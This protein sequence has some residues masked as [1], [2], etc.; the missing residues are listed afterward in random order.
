[1]EHVPNK[2]AFSKV[3]EQVMH[4][5][6]KLDA[7]QTSIKRSLQEYK[8]GKRKLYSFYDGPPFATGLP[9]YGHIL[10]G[11]IKDTVTRY[12][13][14]TGHYVPRRF[15][16]VDFTNYLICGHDL[17]LTLFIARIAMDSPWNSKLTRL[18]ALDPS[19]MCS[20]WA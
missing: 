2:H 13:H 6:D 8:E 16:W 1:M 4:L 9:H 14:M 15:G 12:A 10:A 3:E 7:F 20:I 5:W 11:T 18:R 17:I 19:K